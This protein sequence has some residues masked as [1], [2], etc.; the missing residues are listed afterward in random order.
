MRF[1]QIGMMT[2]GS[3][4]SLYNGAIDFW[5]MEDRL[6]ALH[7][8]N[9]NITGAVTFPDSSGIINRAASFS[10]G[11]VNK[12]IVP[13]STA[14]NVNTAYRSVSLWAKFNTTTDHTIIAK[15][16]D[17]GGL[18][19]YGFKM[20]GGRINAL[21]GSGSGS[22]LSG[23]ISTGTWYHLVMRWQRNSN[24]EFYLNNSLV[25]TADTSPGTMANAAFGL[26]IGGGQSGNGIDGYIDAVGVW[27]KY[28]S[29][30]E[31]TT[32]NNSGAGKQTPF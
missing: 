1:A 3:I 25:S 26:Y 19:D 22:V 24:M 5:N 6:A 29:T 15:Y 27:S 4:N 9:S 16:A 8:L 11:A 17:G 23:V 14:L 21:C 12:L 28:L 20:T 32:L 13:S 2:A 30:G 7:G 31:I 18:V 10:G